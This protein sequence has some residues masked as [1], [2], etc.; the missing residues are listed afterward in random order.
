MPGSHLVA[1]LVFLNFFVINK[2][3][4]IDEH[5][6]G[7]NFAAADVLVNRGENLVDLNGKRARFSLSLPLPNVLFPQAAEMI[8]ADCSGQFDL[9]H[10]FTQ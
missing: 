1:I 4:N 2:V 5:S 6:A 9:F 8:S 3:G 10:G 7:I